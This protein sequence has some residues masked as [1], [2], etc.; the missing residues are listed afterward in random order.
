MSSGSWADTL[1]ARTRGAVWGP[2][3]V[4]VCEIC[5][6][7]LTGRTQRGADDAAAALEAGTRRRRL[8][9]VGLPSRFAP[10]QTQLSNTCLP[11]MDGKKLRLFATL[12]AEPAAAKKAEGGAVGVLPP[13]LL[14]SHHSPWTASCT[15][16]LAAQHDLA[17]SSLLIRCLA[18]GLHS[19]GTGTSIEGFDRQAAPSDSGNAAGAAAST[20][21]TELLA[22]ALAEH[23]V[24]GWRRTAHLAAPALR[25]LL[26]AP[27]VGV[28]GLCGYAAARDAWL[29]RQLALAIDGDGCRQVVVLRAGWS[30]WSHS[31]AQ[32]GVTWF[33]VDTRQAVRAKREVLDDVVPGWRRSVRRPR[34]V[35][36]ALG[37]CCY[38]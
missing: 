33:E 8:H 11:A 17:T 26:E 29:S 1:P 23:L 12:S 15:S 19:T 22:P 7:P 32:E 9:R 24:P 4:F 25:L 20:A 38:P 18:L 13:P 10:L 6:S 27:C 21:D 28:P 3:N 30:T 14:P 16:R 35:E 2:E 37:C 31:L 36:G 34:F 5:V